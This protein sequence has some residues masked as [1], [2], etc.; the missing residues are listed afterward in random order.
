MQ[1][2]Y[3]SICLENIHLTCF[4]FK[5]NCNHI[6]HTK[7]I[8]SWANNTSLSILKCPLCRSNIINLKNKKNIIIHYY[9]KDIGWV[10]T[11][12]S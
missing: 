4:I 11:S 3:C 12:N 2:N 1:C 10:S 8:E 6:F 5:T 9:V 7:C